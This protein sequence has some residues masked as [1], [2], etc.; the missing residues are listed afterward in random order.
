MSILLSYLN[1]DT[2]I[3]EFIRHCSVALSFLLE[4]SEAI[5]IPDLFVWV[6]C[7]L[8]RNLRIFFSLSSFLWN[9]KVIYLRIGLFYTEPL[10]IW[11]LMLSIYEKFFLSY[12]FSDLFSFIFTVYSFWSSLLELFGSWTSWGPPGPGFLFSSFSPIFPKVQL[13]SKITRS[14]IFF[15]VIRT[16]KIYSLAA[17]KYY[18]P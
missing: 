6:F 18:Q 7:F 14:Y 2:A 8:S 16:L 9:C 10:L 11:K 13:T 5:F 4:Q 15:L 17:F 1:S 12:F 3:T